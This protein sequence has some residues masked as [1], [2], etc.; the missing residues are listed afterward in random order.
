[1]VCEGARFIQKNRIALT[2]TRLMFSERFFRCGLIDGRTSVDDPFRHSADALYS[3]QSGSFRI[4]L[5]SRPP[6]LL[7]AAA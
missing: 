6:V 1:M 3:A 7:L 2:V 4:Y 5:S